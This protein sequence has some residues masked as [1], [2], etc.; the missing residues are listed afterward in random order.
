MPSVPP[1]IGKFG[2]KLKFFPQ[3]PQFLCQIIKF[4][5]Q[6]FRV[7]C[8]FKV[9]AKLEAVQ[10]S[11]LALQLET[12]GMPVELRIATHLQRANRST[13]SII[14][15]ILY[16]KSHTFKQK[17]LLTVKK[18]TRFPK[19]GNVLRSLYSSQIF[20]SKKKNN[21]N[22]SNFYDLQVIQCTHI[23]GWK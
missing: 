4:W 13:S 3:H 20:F 7:E 10:F 5:E 1:A 9:W 16:K 6:A 12:Q 19:T 18:V 22:Y 21:K 11:V 15:R 23:P 14:Q 8:A 17:V 2:W